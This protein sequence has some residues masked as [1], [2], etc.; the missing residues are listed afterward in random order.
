M[1]AARVFKVKV[2]FEKMG[3]APAHPPLTI[4]VTKN[5]SIRTI[6]D[7]VSHLISPIGEVE[8]KKITRIHHRDFE[9]GEFF[10]IV[11]ADPV[12]AEPFL[13]DEA[14]QINAIADAPP[15]AEK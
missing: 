4:A 15:S 11:S 12:R 5:S 10:S 13:V 3:D 8:G 7:A 9:T 14:P 1:S 6:D 2:E